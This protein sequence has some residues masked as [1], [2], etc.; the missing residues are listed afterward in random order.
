MSENQITNFTEIRLRSP[1]VEDEFELYDQL[2]GT[3]FSESFAAKHIPTDQTVIFWRCSRK[4]S[5]DSR[6]TADFQ[7]RLKKLQTSGINLPQILASGVDLEGNA[8]MVTPPIEGRLLSQ[9]TIGASNEL[10]F[11]NLAKEVAK[12]HKVG[13][14]L[15]DISNESFLLDDKG[16]VVFLGGL[17]A[18]AF[19]QKTGIEG[20]HQGAL[21]YFSPEFRFKA[22]AT[23]SSDV[24]SLGVL[25]Y[26]L[27]THKYLSE[28]IAEPEVAKNPL[29]FAVAPKSLNQDCP[30]WLNA[31]VLKCV[32]PE[33]N[34]RFVDAN[35]LAIAIDNAIQ[36]GEFPENYSSWPTLELIRRRSSEFKIISQNQSTEL[37]TGR[38]AE[39]ATKSK[40][41]IGSTTTKS[42]PNFVQVIIKKPRYVFLV[43]LIVLLLI[44]GGLLAVNLRKS[45]ESAD[46]LDSNNSLMAHLNL[47]TPEA[48]VVLNN[49]ISSGS[50]IEERKQALNSLIDSEDPIAFAVLA[51]II[52][53]DFAIQPKAELRMHAQQI[54]LD[55]LNKLGF[56]HAAEVVSR[57]L[58]STSK[59]STDYV[60]SPAFME[61]MTSVDP[62]RSLSGR[63][64]AVKQAY[65]KDRSTGMELVAALALDDNENFIG[66]LREVI[67]FE[68]IK[69]TSE[70]N[71][72]AILGSHREL[73]KIFADYIEK[74]ISELSTQDLVWLVKNLVE[75]DSKTFDTALQ[76]YQSRES[77]TGAQKLL[78]EMATNKTQYKIG[79]NVRYA[80]VK[81]AF[82]A[83]KRNDI[84]LITNSWA[85]AKLE[86]V[87]LAICSID[88]QQE[89]QQEAMAVLASRAFHYPVAV[90][91]TKWV[92]E[93][94]WLREL[95]II[96]SVGTLGIAEEISLQ[97]VS[98]AF[99]AIMSYYVGQDFFNAALE[100]KD[101]L[102]I[103]QA[104][105]RLGKVV[106]FSEL[107]PLLTNED[108]YVRIA[109][110]KA[111]TGNNLAIVLQAIFRAYDSEKDNDVVNVYHEQHWVTRDRL[112]RNQ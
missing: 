79:Q 3:V 1:R 95:P 18:A 6:F 47:A 56:S 61:V 8:Y 42:K 10:V 53:G 62:F 50:S 16:Q 104:V 85:G 29:A 20:C 66:P 76:E 111:L 17:G 32:E 19:E 68:G 26:W 70:R 103:A 27:Y 43:G 44:A 24:F 36:N 109:A 82:G 63:V 4:K 101:P 90:S 94:K 71:I 2:H 102:I 54:F 88:G 21:H 40:S 86:K 64:A 67:A 52:R 73:S 39:L 34:N 69:D 49:F 55:K 74:H 105:E 45:Q 35:G 57:W 81:A 59:S 23:K 110:I 25:G 96:K 65:F 108:K 87:L 80:L 98:Q 12:C 37:S 28:A 11:V 9:L 78:L 99:D 48:K 31:I 13:L 89:A 33:A 83:G 92:K 14:S 106:P 97:E 91:L 58:N 84:T 112:R 60:K 100:T 93:K 30:V 7:A 41:E 107:I 51:T 46:L 38:E 72:T 22:V 77:S 5:Q 75:I 15:G